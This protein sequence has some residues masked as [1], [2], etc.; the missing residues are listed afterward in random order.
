MTAS[1]DRLNA[2]V[3]G[4]GG[5]SSSGE[6]SAAG[7]PS[8]AR[9]THNGQEADPRAGDLDRAERVASLESSNRD[10]DA[11]EG[12]KKSDAKKAPTWT[13]DPKDSVEPNPKKNG[14]EEEPAYAGGRGDDDTFAESKK[15]PTGTPTQ[16]NATK[17]DAPG[18]G[19]RSGNET[20]EQQTGDRSVDLQDDKNTVQ[21]QAD[22]GPGPH[23]DG[24]GDNE[25]SFNE[26]KP[27]PEFTEKENTHSVI[28]DLPSDR[29]TTNASGATLRPKDPQAHPNLTKSQD[30]T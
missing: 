30:Q 27:G 9:L 12:A 13:G 14:S 2:T 20:P 1:L 23:N 25:G 5:S 6:S 24:P 16:A 19:T 3:N 22:K 11:S 26:K 18:T 17:I 15:T 29:G 21:N 10:N 28:S 7:R 8:H 4:G